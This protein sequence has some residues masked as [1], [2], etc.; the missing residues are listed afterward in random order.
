MHPD[1]KMGPIA[2][3]DLRDGVHKQV[4]ECIA[5]GAELVMGGFIPKE[6]GFFYPV[7]VLKNIK[8]D[9]PAYDDEIFGPVITF[10]DATDEAEA[11][12]IANDHC[13]GLAGAVFSKNIKHG[14]KVANQ[15]ESGVCFVNQMALSDAR[16]PFGGIKESG[17]G[18]E[19]S[20]E[21][22]REFV[23]IKTVVVR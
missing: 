16:L 23:N 2:R 20:M 15:I 12:R 17:F 8:P 5:K 3:A 9:M 4:Q 7:T 13:Y 14:E 22:I 19:L 6:K 1:T 11:I 21:G 18:R 10:L